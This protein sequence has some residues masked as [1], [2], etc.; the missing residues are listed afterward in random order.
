MNPRALEL[1]SGYVCVMGRRQG[2]RRQ[3][4]GIQ[5]LCQS[6]YLKIPE[7]PRLPAL[8]GVT[9]VGL[10]RGHRVPLAVR[11]R[12]RQDARAKLDEV[13]AAVIECSEEA[14]RGTDERNGKR[15]DIAAVTDFG[16]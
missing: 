1:P 8:I 2:E 12:S 9:H 14:M 16:E 7:R 13:A 10:F 3:A 5:D 4:G 15:H 6:K 11:P